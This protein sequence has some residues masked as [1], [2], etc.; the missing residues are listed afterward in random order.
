[1]KHKFTPLQRARI[2]E[3]R[4]MNRNE[5]DAI[6]KRCGTCCLIKWH[7]CFSDEWGPFGSRDQDTGYMRRCCEH[8]DTKT[9]ECRMYGAR[10]KT[11]NCRQV[12]INTILDDEL[13]PASC[14]YVEYV[15]GP[16]Q[17]PANP[18]WT[19]I[20]PITDNALD[21]L[22]PAVAEREIIPESILWARYYQKMK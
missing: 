20:T 17:I 22:P 14:G 19:Q 5:W 3:L 7:I 10:L 8:L 9:R 12:T 13:L 4:K 18:D 11:D 15:F 21:N 1:M 16:A 6:C 2:N